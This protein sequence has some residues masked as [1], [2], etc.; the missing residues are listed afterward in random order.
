AAGYT[1]WD[2]RSVNIVAPFTYFYL[3]TAIVGAVYG[4]YIVRRYPRA[5]IRD[6]WRRN[7]AAIMQVAF[8]NTT[9]Y[10]LILLALK[11]GVSSYVVALRQLSIA[12]GALLGWN[13]LGER[14]GSAKRLGIALIISGTILV[15]LAR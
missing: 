12:W 6:E 14:I 3:Y 8:F 1:V 9:T 15:A 13:V 7:G 11:N 10:L 2:K 5:T 4:L